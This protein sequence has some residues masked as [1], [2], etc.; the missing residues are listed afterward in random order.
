MT[1][2]NENN[3]FN[4]IKTREELESFI[5]KR[6]YI[7]TSPTINDNSISNSSIFS[8]KLLGI[9]EVIMND[10]KHIL[11]YFEKNKNTTN[12]FIFF[13]LK[14]YNIPITNKI[15]NNNFIFSKLKDAKNYKFFLSLKNNSEKDLE[16]F[17]KYRIIQGFESSFNDL[18]KKLRLFLRNN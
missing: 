12:S 15:K 6:V 3:D 9:T 16:K 13:L 14:D 4:Q 17:F 1:E 5:N 10:K 8:V 18:N 2:K 7:L 11:S